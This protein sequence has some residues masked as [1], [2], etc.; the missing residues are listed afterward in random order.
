MMPGYCAFFAVSQNFDK[1]GKNQAFSIDFCRGRGPDRPRDTVEF[2]VEAEQPRAEVS[3]ES[4]GKGKV[5]A[6]PVGFRSGY[7]NAADFQGGACVPPA[8]AGPLAESAGAPAES[9]GP[10]G[11]GRARPQRDD[12]RVAGVFPTRKT[13]IYLDLLG[14]RASGTAPCQK[15]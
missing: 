4:D 12:W 5:H 11:V 15:N 13:R 1:N 7:G 3:E 2:R 14:A 6:I 9:R 10:A 8:S